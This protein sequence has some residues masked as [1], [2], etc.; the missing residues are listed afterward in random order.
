MWRNEWPGMDGSDDPYEGFMQLAL[1]YVLGGDDWLYDEARRIWDGI[2]WQWTEYGQID[3]E[4][5]KYYDWMHH[6]EGYLY[7]YFLGLANPTQRKDRQRA[8]RF[9]NMYTGH[10]PLAPNYDP[11][12]K[13]IRAPLTGSHGPR[14]EVTA[15]DW[16]TH[17]V[18]LDHYLAPYEDIINTDF[19][20][21]RC[22]WSDDTIYADII[23]KMNQRMNKGDVPLNLNATGLITHA[24]LYN[25]SA[26]LR[27]WI[28]EYI[29]AW[30]ARAERNGGIIPDNVGLNDIIGEYLDGKWWGGY[31]GWRWPH[32]FMTIIEPI[33]NACM[34]ALLIT[35]D[36]RWLTLARQQ[37]D[38]NWA[39]GHE[40]DGQY[41][42][43][44]RHFDNGWGD[45]RPALHKYPIYLWYASLADEDLDRVM[46]IPRHEDWSAI[47]IGR[48]KHYI[49]N[50][51]PWFEYVH[52][53]NPDYPERILA[54]NLT[55]VANQL[56]KMRSPIADPAN[57]SDISGLDQRHINI[58]MHVDPIHA[59]QEFTPVC[60]EGLLQ[61]TLGAPMHISHGGLQFG[62]VRYYD[63]QRRRPGLPEGIA[64]LVSTFD[65]HTI[66]LTVVNTDACQTHELVI[67]AGTFGE[68][69]FARVRICD[70]HGRTLITQEVNGPWYGLHIAPMAGAILHF[71]V[72]RYVNT[73]SYATPWQTPHDGDGLIRG[74]E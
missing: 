35:G 39:L 7:I 30:Q 16:Q 21:R 36:Q 48:G 9:A 19:A 17:R 74:R 18:V 11:Q 70:Q 13:L 22:H 8:Q 61:L 47:Q 24:F 62:Q 72:S 15:E 41:Q 66:T 67:Q 52:G 29:R 37:L 59:W 33:T 2:T 38:A 45:Y 69:R 4:F 20:S 5:T 71:E 32:G 40:I 68:H 23:A 63:G 3:R 64:T 65:Q 73:P 12:H 10:D 1:L 54:A 31:Y 26:D 56:T 14:H 57:W 27:Q 25:Q 58:N 50:T 43:P 28:E 60:V 51:L 42:V 6:G 49:S 44:Y 34:N 46:R 55:L 53:R